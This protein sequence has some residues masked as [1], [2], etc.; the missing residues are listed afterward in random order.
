[1]TGLY[2]SWEQIHQSCWPDWLYLRY[3]QCSVAS[4]AWQLAWLHAGWKLWHEL[5]F[6]CSLDWSRLA[7][8]SHWLREWYASMVLSIAMVSTCTVRRNQICELDW[9]SLALVLSFS[10]HC[11]SFYCLHLLACLMPLGC[12]IHWCLCHDHHWFRLECECSQMPRRFRLRMDLHL[13][14]GHMTS[15]LPRLQCH[16]CQDHHSQGQTLHI[17]Q[18]HLQHQRHLPHKH[19]LQLQQLLITKLVVIV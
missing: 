6:H 17:V 15:L 19:H 4:V 2:W 5:C 7:N 10:V 1:M 3:F 18:V 11:D 13:T 12:F 8:H 14:L 16:H 9:I